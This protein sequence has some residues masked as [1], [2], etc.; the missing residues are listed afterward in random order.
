MTTVR[1]RH[2]RCNHLVLL[3][4]QWQLWRQQRPKRP[5][6]MKQS[7]RY[8]RMRSR[9][10]CLRP[11]IYHRHRRR[12]LHRIKRPLPRHRLSHRLVIIHRHRLNP[13]HRLSRSGGSSDPFFCRFFCSSLAV[14]VA[15]SLRP[16]RAM[17]ARPL[18]TGSNPP[19]S[20]NPN[21][22]RSPPLAGTNQSCI[23][24]FD[25]T[26]DTKSGF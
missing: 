19:S 8:Q 9:N 10:T 26:R 11:V 23:R 4:P 15:N 20:N 3:P 16:S 1:H 13:S 24:R 17:A 7:I 18:I 21:P 25:L 5:K 14:L 2:H 22:L 6:R 12:I